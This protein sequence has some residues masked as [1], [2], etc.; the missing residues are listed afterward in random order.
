MSRGNRVFLV[1]PEVHTKFIIG[2]Q[3]VAG[4]IDQIL[5]RKEI[6]CAVFQMQGTGWEGYPNPAAAAD[7]PYRR[8]G[9]IK[10]HII[11]ERQLARIIDRVDLHR[12]Q[13]RIDSEKLDALVERGCQEID[14]PV[15][16]APAV[17]LFVGVLAQLDITPVAVLMPD[18]FRNFKQDTSIRPGILSLV[19]RINGVGKE[20]RDDRRIGV[21]GCNCHLVN[22]NGVV[23][24][25]TGVV[26]GH[27]V[28][29]VAGLRLHTGNIEGADKVPVLIVLDRN[30]PGLPVRADIHTVD[31]LLDG[32]HA[33]PG[34]GVFTRTGLAQGEVLDAP[35]GKRHPVDS[36]GLTELELHICAV[37]RGALRIGLYNELRRRL[38][39][40]GKL[41][42]GDLPLIHPI[43]VH[44]PQVE[45]II[46]RL[47]QDHIIDPEGVLHILLHIPHAVAQGPG[48]R[49]ALELI[50]RR[51]RG[52]LGQQGVIQLAILVG[53]DHHY[54]V[55]PGHL[56]HPRIPRI[57]C[58]HG[59]IRRSKRDHLDRA[60]LPPAVHQDGREVVGPAGGEP[61][62]LGDGLLVALRHLHRAVFH[63][64]IPVGGRLDEV[65]LAHGPVGEGA[66][67]PVD[68]TGLVG[69]KRGVQPGGHD[70]LRLW[71]AR[72]DHGLLGGLLGGHA[73]HLLAVDGGGDARADLDLVGQH[74][75]GA[76]RGVDRQL[77]DVA[78]SGDLH[79]GVQVQLLD[80]GP[81]VDDHGG[82]HCGLIHGQLGH[83]AAGGPDLGPGGAVDDLADPTGQ[84]QLGGHP[85]LRLLPLGV[86]LGL[87][88][89]ILQP[90]ALG[91]V[92]LDVGAGAHGSVAD[93][94]DAVGPHGDV[95]VL[96]IV[97][98]QLVGGDVAQQ[99]AVR[100][101]L[102]LSGAAGD[103][104]PEHRHVLQLHAAQAHAA[105]DVEVPADHGVPQLHAGGG[106]GHVA[107][108][109]AQG[110]IARLLEG[111]AHQ[112]G[113]H[114]GHLAPAHVALGTEGA[115]VIAA[116]QV[117]LQGGLD[118]PLGPGADL[119]GVGEVQQL[120]VGLLQHHVPPQDGGGRLP[121][122]RVVG[123]GGGG[124]GPVDIPGGVGD[125]HVVVVP[126]LHGH[127]LEGGLPHLVVAVGPV[128]DGH[129]LRS[130][131][132]PVRVSRLILPDEA[133]LHQL[134]EVGVRPVGGGRL[135]RAGEAGNQ[136]QQ[137][138][139]RQ[140]ERDRFSP[141]GA[142]GV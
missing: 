36:T 109:P 4:E 141:P 34:G 53:H 68:R 60:S 27:E 121:R 3:R 31:H 136:P 62:D 11:R 112:G 102:R 76:A 78:L 94:R 19:L 133:P 96:E 129:E 139:Q 123:G 33:G 104:A 128:D 5:D 25:R 137:D 12:P 106:D 124:G 54:A 75:H 13:L 108:H 113:H 105:G 51:S 99:D 81:P 117:V 63:G 59:I 119:P 67:G 52:A 23:S 40:G 22:R 79:A 118:G 70:V 38:I 93:V 90:Q 125:A 6:L 107:V 44:Q 49:A 57:E 72:Q 45:H 71:V 110:V 134:A 116:D 86:G 132:G 50:L 42:A 18:I 21:L 142:E 58:R 56:A 114:G 77:P 35:G 80:H 43:G 9:I 73:I 55:G 20:L 29:I 8:L 91:G 24:V 140:Q 37:G 98:Q 32:M 87:Q 47:I 61:G 111:R 66:D 130:R 95:V 131:Q 1:V 138:C 26:L 126:V 65:L 69:H 89:D 115:V 103:D 2:L 82:P 28:D 85:A 120:A 41:Q 16:R 48:D 46:G 15:V 135:R 84:V 92:V 17:T 101:A 100:A 7:I 97:H 10:G 39:I 74:L 122:E 88:G 14:C 30:L 64:D 127:V 83:G